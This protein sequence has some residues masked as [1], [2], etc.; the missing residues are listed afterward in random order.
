MH[1]STERLLSPQFKP[2]YHLPLITK[3]SQG[4][5]HSHE[6]KAEFKD[7]NPEV[8]VVVFRK[9]N[10]WF[11]IYTGLNFR[12]NYRKKVFSFGVAFPDPRR[13]R[14]KRDAF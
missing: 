4:P 9:P 10:A 3:D 7:R 14:Q 11:I 8:F 5:T 12:Q 6:H 1:C 13:V 2:F